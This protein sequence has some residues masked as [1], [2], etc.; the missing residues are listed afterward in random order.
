MHL[1]A[2]FV[3]NI[4]CCSRVMHILLTD[5]GQMD[6]RTHMVIIVKTMGRAR[7]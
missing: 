4:L 3:Q 1:Y 5:N 7:L 2:K 6:V